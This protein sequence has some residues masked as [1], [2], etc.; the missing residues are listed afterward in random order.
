MTKQLTCIYIYS[1]QNELWTS[2]TILRA[3]GLNL[4]NYGLVVQMAIFIEDIQMYLAI[5]ILNIS[6]QFPSLAIW[7]QN[8]SSALNKTSQFGIFATAKNKK[9]MQNIQ[10][11]HMHIS[12]SCLLS[13]QWEWEANCSLI[14]RKRIWFLKALPWEFLET[15]TGMGSNS[16]SLA[17]SALGGSKPEIKQESAAKRWWGL[18]QMTVYG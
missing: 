14:L 10:F 6:I 9:N 7:V 18:G 8:G 4:W 11:T 3:W 12:T 15:R 5:I 2:Y 16:S 1:F 17:V 13:L